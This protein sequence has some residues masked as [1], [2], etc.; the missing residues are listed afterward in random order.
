MSIHGRL[1]ACGSPRA[2][3]MAEDAVS[4]V[5]RALDAALEPF[6]YDAVVLIGG[7][8]RGEGGV[9]IRGD[10]EA[11]H[12]NLDVLVITRDGA[13]HDLARRVD[14][15]LAPIRGEL[16]VG[17]DAGFVTRA[18][19]ERAPCLVMWL[20]MRN[21][22]KT[23][24][25][26]DSVVPGLERFTASRLLPWD[27]DL[28]VT[29]RASLLVL[30]EL[31]LATGR[32]DD[33]ARRT[34][35]KHAYKAIVGY[36]DGMLFTLGR[37]DSS[38]AEKARRVRESPEISPVLAGRYDEAIRFRFTPDY[39]AFV[40][41]DLRSWHDELVHALGPVHL[42]YV[43]RRVGRPLAWRDL[44]SAVAECALHGDDRSVTGL[45]RRGYRA[46]RTPA[47][48]P[49]LPWLSGLALRGAG[50]RGPLSIALPAVLFDPD[51]SLREIAAAA[52]DVRCADLGSLRRAY[53]AA[54]SHHGD[55]NAP[56]ALVDMG[57]STMGA[58]TNVGVSS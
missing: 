51:E 12:N 41:R 29:N 26:D 36:G 1:T 38:Y 34:V 57:L 6:W 53:A 9:E 8:G 28:L 18:T 2:E 19:L 4:R 24:L 22:H 54:W 45:V 56:A 33:K 50:D 20:D 14:D 21:G 3:H 42:D 10:R 58:A 46:L 13:P 23:L 55:A 30:S 17:V 32:D 37:Y 39:G 16:G 49:S 15:A 40:D 11:L 31:L 35:I 47:N 43:S 7:Y 48:V 27:V 52:L 44:P 5:A 25:G